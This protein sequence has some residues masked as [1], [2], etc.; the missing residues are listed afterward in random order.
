MKSK[1]LSNFE[2]ERLEMIKICTNSEGILTDHLKKMVSETLWK[3]FSN[4]KYKNSLTY[5]E[6]IS[7]TSIG[8]GLKILF[9]NYTAG[10]YSNKLSK[11]SQSQSDIDVI[12]QKMHLASKKILKEEC[13][14]LFTI[15]KINAK[16]G[17]LDAIGYS[18]RIQ[19]EVSKRV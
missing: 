3:S 9:G 4:Y 16:Q 12:E 6:K 2:T 14:E 15:L 11:I 7:G 17:L 5:I 18:L 13:S 19:I 1:F 10:E 8:F